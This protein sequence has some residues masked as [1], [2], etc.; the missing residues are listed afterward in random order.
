MKK[1]FHKGCEVVL[2]IPVG[3]LGSV[4]DP[5]PYDADPDPV[6]H[7]ETDPDPDFQFDTDPDPTV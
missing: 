2:Q 3:L 1:F 5:D 7:F 6:V 4:E